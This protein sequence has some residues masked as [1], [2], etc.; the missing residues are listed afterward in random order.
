MGASMEIRMM[1]D[2][3]NGNDGRDEAAA[4]AEEEARLRTED[5]D[6]PEWWMPLESDLTGPGAALHHRPGVE[7]PNGRA[8]LP[9]A[10]GTG[11]LFRM[12]APA[13]CLP[14]L[15]RPTKPELKLVALAP[16]W[17]MPRARRGALCVRCSFPKK[18]GGKASSDSRARQWRRAW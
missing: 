8:L 5:D 14:T 4:R 6:D 12:G 1:P 9:G 13:S 15:I 17:R 2:K 10:S 7:H 11:R 16:P 18:Y 3:T